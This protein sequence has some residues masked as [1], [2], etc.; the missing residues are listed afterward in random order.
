[1]LTR[2]PYAFIK[3]APHLAEHPA[4]HLIAGDVRTFEFP[5]GIFSHVIHM[6]TESSAKFNQEEPLL[7]LDTIVQGTSHTLDFAQYCHAQK[8]LLTSSGAVYGRQ[9]SDMKF[10]SEDYNGAPDV[11]DP[12]SAYG[13]G[14]RIAELLCLEYSKKYNIE[15]K[16]ARG[17]AFVGPY[18][19]LN[20]HYAIGNFIGD[21]IRGQ[22][23][24]VK[25]DGTPYRSYLY[26]ADA[27]IWLWT[28]LCHG[29]ACRPYNVGSEK[30]MTIAELAA[31]VASFGNPP[32][33]VHIAIQPTPGKP[34][35]RYVP[36][37]KR[38]RT[39][40]DLQQYIELEEAVKRTIRWYDRLENKG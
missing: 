33:K 24:Q 17:F 26:A 20:I 31:R 10:V 2:N 36:L 23:V 37:T 28:I 16:I 11:M 6:A 32:G 15:N 39:E 13:E 12:V 22:P 5:E 9:P 4:I 14:K 27:A 30:D 18:L 38:A 3:K 29:Q 7:M 34:P 1:V 8:F 35:A 40:L 25:G 19:P 21:A